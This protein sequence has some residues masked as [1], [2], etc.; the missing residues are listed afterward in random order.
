MRIIK[1]MLVSYSLPID[2]PWAVFVERSTE[3]VRTGNLTG[4]A[5]FMAELTETPPSEEVTGLLLTILRQMRD[6]AYTAEEM[7]KL[8]R[9]YRLLVELLPYNPWL[10]RLVLFEVRHWNDVTPDV[11]LN[12]VQVVYEKG[13]RMRREDH[14]RMVL[15]WRGSGVSAKYV[16]NLEGYDDFTETDA[17]MPA[18]VRSAALPA[19]LRIGPRRLSLPMKQLPAPKS[20]SDQ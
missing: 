13:K 2:H 20:H 1:G 18:V 3:A 5:S 6:P 11:L 19:P 8:C 9:F 10:Y 7:R 14:G 12:A 4:F 16:Q 17:D 15:D